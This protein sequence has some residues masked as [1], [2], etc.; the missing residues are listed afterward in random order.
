MLAGFSLFSFLCNLYLIVQAAL[1]PKYIPSLSTL[2]TI[3]PSYQQPLAGAPS[4]KY[5]C[6]R[7]QFLG[8]YLE[9]VELV[10]F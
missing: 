10:L 8:M 3:R 2:L 9:M 4:R 1:S 6:S 7:I 5:L